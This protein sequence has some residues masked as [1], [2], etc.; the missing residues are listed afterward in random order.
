MI[1][2]TR[3]VA[4]ELAMLLDVPGPRRGRP[5]RRGPVV[6]RGDRGLAEPRRTGFGGE[7]SQAADHAREP[8]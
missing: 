7:Q 3:A 2:P 6:V 5:C 8:A 4:D 1:V